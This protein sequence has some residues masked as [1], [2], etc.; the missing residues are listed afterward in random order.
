MIKSFR[1]LSSSANL[2]LELHHTKCIVTNPPSGM[3][4]ALCVPA[5]KQLC[6]TALPYFPIG[7]PVPRDIPSELSKGSNTWGG[8]DVGSNHMY[9]SQT[10]DGMVTSLVGKELKEVVSSLPV[11]E[12]HDG[13]EYK[14][15]EG[16]SVVTSAPYPLSSNYEF[17]I[18]TVPPFKSDSNAYIK[19][20][21]CYTSILD[22]ACKN[23]KDLKENKKSCV[24]APW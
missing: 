14:C 5:N 16:S 3:H 7:G 8:M 4:F 17:L 2:V 15:L 22:T 9:A 13:I 12:V 19:L 23:T 20:M 21:S 10:V 18:H 1:K 6:G 11:L 24:A